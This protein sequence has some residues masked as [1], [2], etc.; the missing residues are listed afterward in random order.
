MLRAVGL[1]LGFARRVSAP[2][3]STR[4]AA[5]VQASELPCRRPT[6][7]HAVFDAAHRRTTRPEW[8]WETVHSDRRIARRCEGLEGLKPLSQS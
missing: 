6:C 7:L 8:V 3:G 1:H 2:P 5:P 4:L